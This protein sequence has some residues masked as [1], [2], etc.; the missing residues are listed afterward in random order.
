MEHS[1]VL[2]E[3][4][5]DVVVRD[6]RHIVDRMQSYSKP[7]KGALGVVNTKGALAC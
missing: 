3:A 5:R 2:W 6:V 7:V 1:K 4:F